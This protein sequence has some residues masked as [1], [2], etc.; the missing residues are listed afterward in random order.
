MLK[1]EE[2]IAKQ[3]D[4]IFLNLATHFVDQIKV[5]PPAMARS[6]RPKFIKNAEEWLRYLHAPGFAQLQ[7][8]ILFAKLA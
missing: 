7:V 4:V 3:I 1:V 2:V 8:D 6:S 5:L